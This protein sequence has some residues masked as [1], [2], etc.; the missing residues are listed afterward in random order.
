MIHLRKKPNPT[1]NE[2]QKLW[3]RGVDYVLGTDEVGRGSF[4]GPVVAASVILKR[5]LPS[6]LLNNI[7]D[8]KILTAK[9]RA[10][11]SPLIKKHSIAYSISVI[12]VKTI[13]RYG[14]GIAT[15]KALRKSITDVY[16]KLLDSNSNNFK[17]HLLMDGLYVKHI[18]NF[19]LNNQK[20][21][22]KG[23][24]ISLSIAAASIIAKVYRDLI[25]EKLSIKY[26]EYKW[27]QNKG[28]GT[29]IHRESIY[30]YGLS[31]IHR[32]SFKIS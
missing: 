9:K 22:I 16:S 7:N 30:K 11:L 32:N 25:M 21:I 10:I 20:A 27:G 3:S 12:N 1:F 18:R 17:S 28:Y 13:D 26:P 29:K 6:I 31:S 4:A 2:E 15:K 24:Q 19:G 23:D 8:S 14:I 5:K